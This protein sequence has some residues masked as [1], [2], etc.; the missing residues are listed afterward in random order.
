[1]ATVGEIGLEVVGECIMTHGCIQD[2]GIM[3][4]G[5]Q[6]IMVMDVEVG[7]ILGGDITATDM[8]VIMVDITATVAITV[9]VGTVVEV[10]ET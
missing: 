1:M 3:I 8:V 10:M 6:A 4:L 5:I 7:T 9:V 2:G